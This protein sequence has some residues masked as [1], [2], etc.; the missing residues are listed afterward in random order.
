MQRLTKEELKQY[1]Q[2]A[3]KIH[4]LVRVVDPPSCRCG[5]AGAKEAQDPCYRVWGKSS[6]CENCVSAH[7]VATGKTATKF[8]FMSNKETYYVVSTPIELEDG[9]ILTIETVNIVNDDTLLGAYGHSEFAA[10]IIEY[11]ETRTRDSGTGMFN[12]GYLMEQLAEAKCAKGA[13]VSVMMCD[14]DHFK[15]INDQFG[16]MQ[17]DEVLT[18]VAK[19]LRGALDYHINGFV[20]RFGGDE[21]VLVIFEQHKDFLK[22]LLRRIKEEMKFVTQKYAERFPVEISIGCA[23]TE[24]GVA[25]DELLS[26]SDRQMYRNK[27]KHHEEEK[28][29]PLLSNGQT[30]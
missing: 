14:V 8:E 3:S 19:A 18:D 2:V 24:D 25:V 7:A 20:A 9:E 23:S 21:F 12:K 29:L 13:I 26:E 27:K 16:H 6:R 28:D 4:G 17:G 22:E 10:H 1:L 30:L 11:N 5:G 15:Y